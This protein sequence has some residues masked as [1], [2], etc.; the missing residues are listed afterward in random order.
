ME[1]S[2]INV[3]LHHV[4]SAI[5]IV[6]AFVLSMTS[7]PANRKRQ[8]EVKLKIRHLRKNNVISIGATQNN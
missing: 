7:Y 5:I 8:K 4:H 1:T 6:F 2:N 3:K